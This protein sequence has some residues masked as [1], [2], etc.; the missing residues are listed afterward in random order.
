MA[1]RLRYGAQYLHFG[2]L[3]GRTAAATRHLKSTR[4][5]ARHLDFPDV[6]Q[7]HTPGWSVT[8]MMHLE[9]IRSRQRGSSPR[10]QQ[11][12]D[13]CW[14]VRPQVGFRLAPM[15]AD[16]T[17]PARSLFR[18]R[19]DRSELSC[20]API[21]HRFHDQHSWSVPPAQA[22]S[23]RALARAEPRPNATWLTFD[24]GGWVKDQSTVRSDPPGF[25]SGLSEALAARSSPCL[26]APRRRRDCRCRP[27]HWSRCRRSSHGSTDCSRS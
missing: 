8:K 18:P 11:L 20:C 9:D 10:R 4:T 13:R 25:D 23:I 15:A 17:T 27:N 24:A 22:A 26:I 7:R 1:T 2:R 14:M 3:L 6:K 12:R 16:R 21:F 19:G 5:A